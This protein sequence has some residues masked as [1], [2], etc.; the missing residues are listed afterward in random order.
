M[1]QWQVLN[2]VEITCCVFIS[3]DWLEGVMGKIISTLQIWLY[4]CIVLIMHVYKTLYMMNNFRKTNVILLSNDATIS[5]QSNQG[6]IEI[7]LISLIFV[8][9]NF[10]YI[11]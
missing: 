1:Q 2:K 3:Y 4:E 11:R 5:R 6:G 8:P 7:T 10:G 9:D